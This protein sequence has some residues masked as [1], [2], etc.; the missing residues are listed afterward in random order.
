MASL[1]VR[2]LAFTQERGITLL[3]EPFTVGAS[4]GV[5]S[6]LDVSGSANAWTC[7]V[8]A[9]VPANPNRCHP[10]ILHIKDLLWG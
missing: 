8:S 10:D 7:N 9:W 2:D 3:E 1:M 6:G 4:H 5:N